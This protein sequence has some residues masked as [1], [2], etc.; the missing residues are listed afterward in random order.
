M[1]A[2]LYYF[3][4]SDLYPQIN[5]TVQSIYI[6]VYF[7][8]T[9]CAGIQQVTDTNPSLSLCFSLHC[10]AV[11]HSL[12]TFQQ[13]ANISLLCLLGFAKLGEKMNRS[14]ENFLFVS[15]ILPLFSI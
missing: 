8:T 7:A 1:F 2:F 9:T 5:T 11:L 12:W 3:V 6:D 10:G 14:G 15:P 13:L 4:F